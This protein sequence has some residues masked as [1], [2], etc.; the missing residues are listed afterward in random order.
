[1]TG[2]E[3]FWDDLVAQGLLD[4]DEVDE[5]NRL[6]RKH[7]GAPDTAILEVRPLGTAEQV[8]LLRILARA[9]DAPLAPPE[10][11]E[12]PE[13]DALQFF[14]RE[15]AARHGLLAVHVQPHRLVVVTPA[16]GP[17]VLSELSFVV[18][19]PIEP[20][21]ALELDVRRALRRHLDLPLGDR[22]GALDGRYPG[23]PAGATSPPG[24]P[25]VRA[26][27]I[28]PPADPLASNSR[29][30]ALGG[31]DAPEGRMRSPL[32]PPSATP[33][34]VGAP[35]PEVRVAT[36]AEIQADVRALADPESRL[37]A[38]ARLLAAGER[39]LDALLAVFPGPLEV[40][41]YT[42]EPGRI[43][44]HGP[45]IRALRRFGA[46]ARGPVARLCDS[47]S[48]EVRFYAVS[49]LGALDGPVPPGL[50]D[51]LFDKDP[52]VRAAAARA[53]APHLEGQLRATVAPRLR[54]AL[55]DESAPRRR[56]AAE[57]AGRLRADEVLPT[58]IEA[59]RRP[60]DGATE[61]VHRAL[62]ELT[63]H[64]LGLDAR[65]WSLWYE[66]NRH[67]SRI[68]WLLDG[69]AS[70]RRHSR[71]AAF[72]ELKRITCLELGFG[73]DASP[74]ERRAAIERWRRWWSDDGRTRFAPLRG[75]PSIS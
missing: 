43:D 42:A 22:F 58:L 38:E 13:P 27:R 26:I 12:R 55:A 65:R 50:A 3:R 51:R 34:P 6:L 45:V 67:R 49:L 35:P 71:A 30:R 68:E 19:R 14:P 29:F 40:D 15:L 20:Y 63:R 18:G 10:F 72:D 36:D 47:L 16:L 33:R 53:L 7:G 70:E 37:D 44:E 48:P 64:D 11:L 23:A 28:E 59:L 1:M 74:A 54:D 62:V 32:D 39:G 61:A 9:L 4:H 17:H 73:V 66:Q 75:D 21:L 52:S 31:A 60:A 41:R 24:A 5:A 46:A 56:Y 2:T 57:A 8:R 69:L 25:R